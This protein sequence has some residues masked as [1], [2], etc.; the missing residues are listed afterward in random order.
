[1]NEE[2][3]LLAGRIAETCLKHGVE[4]PRIGEM[5]KP[6]LTKVINLINT[7]ESKIVTKRVV[8][9]RIASGRDVDEMEEAVGMFLDDGWEPSGSIVFAN[10]EFNQP[11][12][13]Y[14][15]KRNDQ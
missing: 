5:P 15:V 2:I 7:L 13:K 6:A 1:M 14:G 9:Y 8:E 4:P 11:M 10:G 12:I 3:T